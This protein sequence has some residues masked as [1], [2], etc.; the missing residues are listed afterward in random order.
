MAT[1]AWDTLVIMM[2]LAGLSTLGYALGAL[3]L[4]GAGVSFFLGLLIA[5]LPGAGLS[6][7]FL[8]VLFTG[9]GVAATRIGYAKK[10]QRRIAEGEAG[11]RGAKNVMGN[12]SAAALA[13]MATLVDGVP[14]LAVQLSFAT[15]VA[16]VAADT[17][18]SEIGQLAA[19]A[20]TVLP[21]FD[22]VKPGTN[23]GVSWPGQIAALLAAVAIA[24]ASV[25]LVGVPLELAWLPA[26][27]GFLGC[28]LDSIL[29]AVWEDD[30]VAG[31]PKGR[32][33][34]T[35]QDVNFLASAIPAFVVL[36]AARF[37]L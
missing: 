20:R 29:G 16:V 33:R 11:E 31:A 25:Y 21:P 1:T 32:R 9:M 18:A 26:V 23:G 17:L 22:E 10:K 4:L 5:L 37:A 7:L 30:A 14:H 8:L 28:Q 12:G 3:D 27:A 13:A 6:W 36:V 2:A 15:A 34:L 19:R 24:A 35:K